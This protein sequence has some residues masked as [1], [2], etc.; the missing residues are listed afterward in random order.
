MPKN[1]TGSRY[2]NRFPLKAG[3]HSLPAYNFLIEGIHAS[4]YHRLKL[5][6]YLTQF[7]FRPSIICEI[8]SALLYVGITTV[9]VSFIS[10]PLTQIPGK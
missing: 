4:Y 5:N 6:N 10:I 7:Y 8:K 9:I 2:F 3:K 1:L